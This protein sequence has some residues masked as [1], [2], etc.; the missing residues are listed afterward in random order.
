MGVHMGVSVGI[1]MGVSM[2]S[3][4]PGPRLH[5]R[6]VERE[7]LPGLQSLPAHVQL[8]RVGPQPH[9]HNELRHSIH[10]AQTKVEDRVETELRQS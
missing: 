6:R 9:A 1:S 2:A 7:R 4:G 8:L 3:V 10:T 5:A